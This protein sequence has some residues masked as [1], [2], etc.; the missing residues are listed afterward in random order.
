MCMTKRHPFAFSSLNA[1]RFPT[2][3]SDAAFAYNADLSSQ[4]ER[5][6]L[7]TGDN[8]TLY[9]PLISRISHAASHVP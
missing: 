6:F 1:T 7:L 2:A 8:Q 4:P 9:Q 5:V 3:Y